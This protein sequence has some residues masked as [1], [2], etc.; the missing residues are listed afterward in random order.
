[1]PIKLDLVGFFSMVIG[2]EVVLI[3]AGSETWAPATERMLVGHK[4]QSCAT[5]AF[6]CCL[7]LIWREQ[8]VGRS[9]VAIGLS[10]TRTTDCTAQLSTL[11][12]S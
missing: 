4:Q 6:C 5:T 2:G 10:L 12:V 11:T 8:H 3:L 9:L 7:P 1:M